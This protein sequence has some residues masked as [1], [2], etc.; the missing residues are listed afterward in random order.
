M[1]PNIFISRISAI[2]ESHQHP[3]ASNEWVISRL[4]AS[5]P[6]KPSDLSSISSENISKQLNAQK[7]LRGWGS[8]TPDWP[9][10][11]RQQ[12]SFDNIFYYLRGDN[13]SVG[14]M[15][16]NMAK[17][18]KWTALVSFLANMKSPHLSQEVGYYLFHRNPHPLPKDNGYVI[19]HIARD[20][21]NHI[22][23]TLIPPPT[24]YPEPSSAQSTAWKYKR[25]SGHFSVLHDC[26]QHLG[27]SALSD[28][29]IFNSLTQVHDLTQDILKT[30]P[31]KQTKAVRECTYWIRPTLSR[32][33]L[34]Q[35]AKVSQSE[36]PSSAP[37]TPKM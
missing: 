31:S 5:R 28:R 35:V 36:T 18:E 13:L 30:A 3:R 16:L 15:A 21:L 29:F 8:K 19:S 32:R 27:P 37:P 12:K 11:S 14:P 10:S 4:L 2:V 34:N 1:K 7:I 17:D 33:A 25:L 20:V 24:K 9:L 23:Q 6:V 26:V 22:K